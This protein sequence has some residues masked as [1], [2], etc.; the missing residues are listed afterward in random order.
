METGMCQYLSESTPG[1]IKVTPAAAQA[2]TNIQA[3][4]E[5]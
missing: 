3:C 4:Y 5:H 1:T 2:S